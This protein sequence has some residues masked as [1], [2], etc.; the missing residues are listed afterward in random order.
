MKKI[1]ILTQP[2]HTNYGGIIQN[3]ALSRFLEKEGFNAQTINR[4][5]KNPHSKLKIVLSELKN[6]FLKK[7]LKRNNIIL[8]SEK[9]IISKNHHDFLKKYISLTKEID[10]TKDLKEFFYTNN[11]HAVIVGSDQTW[12]PKYSPN[13]YNYFLDFL[14]NNSGIKKIAYASSFGTSDWEFSEE[15]TEK[16]ANLVKQFDAVSV[17]EKSGKYLCKRYLTIDSEWTLDPTMLLNKDDYMKIANQK[18]LPNRS[19]ILSYILDDNEEIERI[20]MTI[21]KVLNLNSFTN[22]PKYR[23]DNIQNQNLEDL[24]YP[25]VEGWLKSFD[26]ADFIVTNSFHGTVFSI[27]FNK[28]F[29]TIVNKQRGASRFESL[30]KELNLEDRLIYENTEMGIIENIINTP[31]DYMPIN[32]RLNILRKK[33]IDFLINSL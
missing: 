10:D 4:V 21:K 19:G 7:V 22:Q 15:E 16:C 31:I 25:P 14:E 17:R 13:I 1:A 26:D 20:I 32:E 24:I 33:S 3:Y 29:L 12:R 30:L 9:I 2:L 6:T 8:N 27:I 23:F 28:P 18:R 11:F 5:P